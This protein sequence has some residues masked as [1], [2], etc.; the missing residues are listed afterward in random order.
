MTHYIFQITFC[1][2]NK[3]DSICCNCVFLNQIVSFYWSR[4]RSSLQYCSVV[5]F[6]CNKVIHQTVTEDKCEINYDRQTLQFR[7][8]V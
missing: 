7:N 4:N 3:F 5:L 6:L 2:N 1:E 8:E